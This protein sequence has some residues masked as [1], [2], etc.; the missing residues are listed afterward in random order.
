MIHCGKSLLDH[1]HGKAHEAVADRREER[2]QQEPP[3]VD[4]TVTMESLVPPYSS[5]HAASISRM[6]PN[7]QGQISTNASQADQVRRRRQLVGRQ[8]PGQQV[9]LRAGAAGGGAGLRRQPRVPCEVLL[10]VVD[11][12]HLGLGRIAALCYR[13]SPLYRIREHIRCLF[14]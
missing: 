13:S 8:P 11:A 2:A 9:G 3:D 14:F 5:L 7:R 4:L 1:G 12:L 10:E 6:V